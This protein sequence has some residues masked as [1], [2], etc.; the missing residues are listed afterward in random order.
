MIFTVSVNGVEIPL[1]VLLTMIIQ[2][3]DEYES[4]YQ[5]ILDI[6]MEKKEPEQCGE[7]L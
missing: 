2:Q 7:I 4:K 5:Q 6:I 1:T 3:I